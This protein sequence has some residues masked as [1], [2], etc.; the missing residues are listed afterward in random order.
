MHRVN[1]DFLFKGK[2]YKE[3]QLIPS[4]H[5][6]VKYRTQFVDAVRDDVEA[7]VDASTESAV[8]TVPEEK[9]VAKVS[10][11]VNKVQPAKASVSQAKV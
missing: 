4:N 6:A 1:H 11:P 9:V 10:T 7:S 2:R 5:T 8:K 3:G